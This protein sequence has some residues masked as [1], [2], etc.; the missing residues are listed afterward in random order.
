MVEARPKN[1]I[2]NSGFFTQSLGMNPDYEIDFNKSINQ[3]VIHVKDQNND[4][5]SPDGTSDKE[6]D[7]YLLTITD[8]PEELNLSSDSDFIRIHLPNKITDKNG[9]PIDSVVCRVNRNDLYTCDI[10]SSGFNQ[11]TNSSFININEVIPKDLVSF[12]SVGCD[13][14]I[15]HI[16]EVIDQDFLHCE[17]NEIRINDKDNNVL[18]AFISDGNGKFAIHGSDLPDG[19]IDLPNSIIHFDYEHHKEL[20]KNEVKVVF[21]LMPEDIDYR[22]YTFNNFKNCGGKPSYTIPYIK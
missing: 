10:E 15:K 3:E 18:A 2:R 6:I 17:G 21:H 13:F 9:K 14:D 16:A 4:E 1:A 12:N 20:F 8:I 5:A 11:F 19:C 7:N 22:T